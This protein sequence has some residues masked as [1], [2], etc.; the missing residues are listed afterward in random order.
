MSS[1]D[2]KEANEA[3]LIGLFFAKRNRTDNFETSSAY[4]RAAYTKV[5]RPIPYSVKL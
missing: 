3:I 5:I 2:I 4:E 1:E